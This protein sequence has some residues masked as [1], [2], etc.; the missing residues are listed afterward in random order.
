MKAGVGVVKRNK[1]RNSA[2]FTVKKF[3]DIPPPQAPPLHTCRGGRGRVRV[4]L[5]IFQEFPLQ[6]TKNLDFTCFS[7]AVRRKLNSEGFVTKKRVIISETPAI[8][9]FLNKIQKIKR[10]RARPASF[11]QDRYPS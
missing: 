4:I 10:L 5:P 3:N 9:F 1:Y 7:E 8:L 11:F 2:V 6:T